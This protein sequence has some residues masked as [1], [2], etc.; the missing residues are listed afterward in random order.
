MKAFVIDDQ[1]ALVEMLMN[2]AKRTLSVLHDAEAQGG[3]GLTARAAHE[4]LC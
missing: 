1:R 4:E 3:A 2:A